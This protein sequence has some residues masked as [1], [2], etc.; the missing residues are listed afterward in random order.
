MAKRTAIINIGELVTCADGAKFGK[1][2]NNI[3]I[4]HNA[5]VIIEDDIIQSVGTISELSHQ[6]NL[7]DEIIN[8]DGKC[9]LPGFVDSHTHF[10][11]GGYREDEFEWRLN[12]ESYMSIMERGG[13][14]ANSVCATRSATVAE[15]VKT[16]RIRL[17][18]MFNYGIT[19][20]EGKSGYGLDIDTELRQLAVMRELNDSQPLEIAITYMGAHSIPVEFK[21][22]PESYIDI[23]IN[24]VL[25][26]AANFAE[27]CDVFCEKNVFS[28]DQSRK[29]LTAAQR[30]GLKS[31]L[32]ADEIVQLGG[33]ELAAE[34]GA[35]SADHLLNASDA[36]ITAMTDSKVVCTLLPATAFSLREHYARARYMIDHGACVALASDFNPGSCCTASI[37]LVIALAALNMQMTNAEIITALTINGAKAI[38][39]EHRIGSIE[40]G[41][42]A[43]LLV[44]KYSSHKFLS[45][46]IAE[47]IVKYVIKKGQIV[48]RNA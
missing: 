23:I 7:C 37:P 10:I 20:V 3:G 39:R 48:N 17:A 28:I 21:A 34:L 44:L 46:R 14:I 24:D 43:D 15:L 45:Y 33:A 47:N 38:N 18:E 2:M 22:D 32:H 9:V 30:L 27:F 11:F 26:K 31:K 25:P 13:G 12:G 4:I 1:A 29:I 42:Q 36:G 19:T 5:I 35:V 40:L 41:K 8:A 16:G 6:A